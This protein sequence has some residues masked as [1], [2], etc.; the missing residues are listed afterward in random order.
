MIGIYK[1]NN[2]I[3]AAALEMTQEEGLQIKEVAP[4]STTL[5]PVL[6]KFVDIREIKI[7]NA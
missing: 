3:N 6:Q 5:S 1:E 2:T 4:W 7:F